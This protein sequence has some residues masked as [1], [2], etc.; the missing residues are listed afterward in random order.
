MSIRIIVD[1][2]S[3]IISYPREELTVLPMTITFDGVEYKDGVDITHTQFFEKLIESDALPTTSQITPFEYEEAIQKAKDAG[4]E[5]LIITLSSEL[6]GTYQ[7][8]CIAAADFEGVRV[9]DSL[10]VAVGERAL[11]ERAFVLLDQGKTLD[12]IADDLDECKMRLHVLAVLDTLEYLKKGGRIPPA[13][14]FAGN[15][16][17]IKPV[18]TVVEGKVVML[19]KARGSK[20]G[21][22]FLMQQCEKAG[23]DFDMPVCLGYTGFSDAMIKKYAE[24]SA[25]LW[26]DHLD[27]LPIYSIG[28]TIG[29]HVGPGAI[30]VA[31]FSP[32]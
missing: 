29:T 28:G 30:A 22:N 24:D 17:N 11:V 2:G 31:L 13:V 26:K 9:V 10:N 3:D 12:E 21:N 23:I 7:S 4:E 32:A 27:S 15:V 25:S 18:V 1:S 20:Q 16:L 5:V 14:A 6:S 19:G 8:A